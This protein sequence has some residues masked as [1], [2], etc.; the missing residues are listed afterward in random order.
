MRET[1]DYPIELH[2]AV[3]TQNQLE[4]DNFFF[5][6]ANNDFFTVQELLKTNRFLVIERNHLLETG[7]HVALKESCSTKLVQMLLDAQSDVDARDL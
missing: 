7:L 1:G 5:A 4:I 6:C 2:S 3:A